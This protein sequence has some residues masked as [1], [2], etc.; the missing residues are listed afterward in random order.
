M[1][2]QLKL[3][4]LIAMDDMGEIPERLPDNAL[5]L[6]EQAQQRYDQT[7]GS[8]FAT[9]TTEDMVPLADTQ[10]KTLRPLLDIRESIEARDTLK[11]FLRNHI[12]VEE[13][14]SDRNDDGAVMPEMELEER[15]QLL[16]DARELLVW[17]KEAANQRLPTKIY[18]DKHS[19]IY[20]RV[21]AVQSN[22][23]SG[24]YKEE[25]SKRDRIIKNEL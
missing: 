9:L 24:H 23:L 1:V 11:V 12:R 16:A 5:E 21:N 25:Q 17:V 4:R 18:A 13:S 19:A 8:T 6:V 7:V 2:E 14:R 10:D 22:S 3:A 15:A 20:A